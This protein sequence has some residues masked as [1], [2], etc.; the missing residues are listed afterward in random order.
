MTSS[1]ASYYNNELEEWKDVLHFHAQEIEEFEVW[2]GEIIQGNTVPNLAAQAEH[3]FA[4]FAGQRHRFETLAGKVYGLQGQ[5]LKDDE[6]VAD[7][8]ITPGIEASQNT[9]R[10]QMLEAEKG[11]L[12]L[13]Y[14][15]HKFISDTLGKQKR[16]RK[17]G[18]K[19]DQADG[20][21]D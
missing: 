6:P 14:H 10:D 7:E 18:P 16:G 3:Y 13:K 21:T 12:E 9:L 19:D 11:F 8:L 5:L 17:E 2:L 20:P 1:L 15:C 4:Q